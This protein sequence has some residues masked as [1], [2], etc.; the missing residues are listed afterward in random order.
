MD[1]PVL[2]TVMEMELDTTDTE[3]ADFRL[4]AQSFSYRGNNRSLPVVSAGGS[5]SS[6]SSQS[7]RSSN[8]SSGMSSWS[9]GSNHLYAVA[10]Y[11]S[12]R[13]MATLEGDDV[14]RDIAT[15]SSTGRAALCSRGG[16]LSSTSALGEDEEVELGL[17]DRVR[18]WTRGFAAMALVFRATQS[19][20]QH[21]QGEDDNKLRLMRFAEAANSIML[22]FATDLAADST[23]RPIDKFSGLMD[24]HICTSHVSEILVPSLLGETRRL[25]NSEMLSLLNKIHNVFQSTKDNLGQAIH[26]ITKDAEAVT[27]VLSW[28]S[29]E[30]CPEKCRNPQGYSNVLK[31]IL[32][33]CYRSDRKDKPRD[34]ATLI[35]QMFTNLEQ[36]LEKKSESFSDSSLRYR[37]LLNSS[38]FVREEFCIYFLRS[39]TTLT[40]MQYHEKFMQYHEK[41]MLVSW[42]PVLSFLHNKMPMWFP[43]HSSKLARF[44]SEFQKA[45]IH[46]KLWKVPNPK[47][48]QELREAI[49]GKVITG[50]KRYLEDHP[51]LEK[52]SSD[53]QDMEDMFLAITGH[54]LPDIRNKYCYYQSCSLNHSWDTVLAFL[55]GKMPLWFY[56]PSQLA[57]FRSEFQRTCKHQKLWKVRNTVLRKMLRKAITDR[58][59]TGPTGYKKY[60][61]D[62]PEQEKCSSD[63]QDMEDTVNELFEGS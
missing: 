62:H 8:Y 32:Y 57:R 39:G 3:P 34:L 21:L 7:L 5:S 61:E 13:R 11:S 43:K 24:V 19:S 63:P 48:R 9:G 4:P 42:E 45:C 17:N 50:Y 16:S 58:V 31:D 41:Y 37:F 14:H 28:D 27:P 26:C 10:P 40:F 47:L 53:L 52:C 22:A 25:P 12:F 2:P 49:I 33:I 20:L 29:L 59:I 23:R 46:H 30:I 54:S 36:H 44:K 18:S 60:Q 38:Y 15:T 55:H 6:S 51:E 56:K 1:P 35:A